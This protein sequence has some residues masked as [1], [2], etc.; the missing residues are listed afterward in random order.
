M[1]G[2]VIKSA[3]EHLTVGAVS[4]ETG[5]YAAMVTRGQAYYHAFAPA[6]WPMVATWIR[7]Q[8]GRRTS[9][10]IRLVLDFDQY[11]LFQAQR[12]DDNVPQS[13]WRQI[14]AL[15]VR[16]RLEYPVN[17]CQI[18]YFPLPDDVRGAH[19]RVNVVVAHKPRL[20]KL[21]DAIHDADLDIDAISVP[22]LELRHLFSSDLG[23]EV[24]KGLCVTAPRKER[25][26]FLL[27]RNSA[28]YMTR[29]LSGMRAWE[30]YL[31]P[32]DLDVRESLLLEMQRT[33]D[34]YQT[35]LQQPPVKLALVPDWGGMTD[36]LA[37][38]LAANLGI[39]IKV[40][41]SPTLGDGNDHPDI[42]RALTLADAAARVV[43]DGHG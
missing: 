38:Y 42:R 20:K 30:E 36:D 1:W 40:L 7:S 18:D 22:E 21:V 41:T 17:E 34:F 6:D 31:M 12:P 4:T 26:A 43:E 32:D 19:E 8:A 27:Y 11:Q 39:E 24:G 10:K 29:T 16:D 2:K 5:I 14:L 13:D 25:I 37:G 35:Q 9:A 3:A 23:E 15:A 33:L 28:L